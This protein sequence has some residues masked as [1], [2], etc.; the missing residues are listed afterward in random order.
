MDPATKPGS[1]VL[2]KEGTRPP[3]LPK[4]WAFSQRFYA[5]SRL[6]Q[7]MKGRDRSPQCSLWIRPWGHLI[8]KAVWSS[9][10]RFGNVSR[11]YTW[12]HQS[13]YEW[14]HQSSWVASVRTRDFRL[15][16]DF[17]LDSPPVDGI[18]ATNTTNPMKI[19]KRMTGVRYRH[20]GHKPAVTLEVEWKNEFLKKKN[21]K[22]ILRTES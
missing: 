1:K 4:I 20:R 15:L 11:S 18:M 13:S 2:Q 12:R 10:T 7:S 8:I 14:R 5:I 6:I 17:R 9:L 19:T 22:R 16:A 3:D 21:E